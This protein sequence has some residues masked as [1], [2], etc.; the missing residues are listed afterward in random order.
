MDE[1]TPER[2]YGWLDSQLSIAR[3]YGGCEYNGASY[4]IDW[5]ADGHPLVRED[6][7][8]GERKADKAKAA[9]AARAEKEA[10]ESA[11][12]SLLPPNTGGKP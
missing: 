10:W 7:L 6:V 4:V 5:W 12:V 3:Y 2:I 1:R 11:S 9:A 8:R